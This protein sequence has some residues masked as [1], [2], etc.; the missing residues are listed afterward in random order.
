MP[1]TAID[2]ILLP[3]LGP[4]EIEVVAAP[5]RNAEIGL[6]NAA[7]HFLIEGV[8]ER[9]QA[10]CLGFGVGVLAFQIADDIR[11]L[12][13]A[14]PMIVIHHGRTMTDLAVFDLWRNRRR[15]SCILSSDQRA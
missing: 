8:R 6:L 14:Q 4:G 12:F 10:L 5:D 2:R 7:Q 11:I 3:F 13:V 15:L 1:A 9:L